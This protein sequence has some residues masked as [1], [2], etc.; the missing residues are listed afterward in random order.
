[1][2]VA[3]HHQQLAS[4]G[5]RFC[6]LNLIDEINCEVLGI[7]ADLFLLATCAVRLLAQLVERCSRYEKLRF[8]NGPEVISATLG[9]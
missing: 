9:V 8:G 7:G 1:M 6:T 3:V 2:R 4:V 5:R